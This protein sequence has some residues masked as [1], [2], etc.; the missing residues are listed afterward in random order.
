ME[1]P[2]FPAPDKTVQET[3]TILPG[4]QQDTEQQ[5]FN[6]TPAPLGRTPWRRGELTAPNTRV[7]HCQSR[8]ALLGLCQGRKG[9]SCTPTH[10]AAAQEL[11]GAAAAHGCQKSWS[12]SHPPQQEPGGWIHHFLTHGF[13]CSLRCLFASSSALH[14]NLLST[15]SALFLLAH[16]LPA[17]SSC[18][19]CRNTI[20]RIHPLLA[21]GHCASILREAPRKSHPEL[22]VEGRM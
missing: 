12:L 20:L 14:K 15:S 10:L 21:P 5:S 18:P 22:S 19:A 4:K 16:I 17:A 13:S 9:W 3:A 6:L 11:S 1:S 7:G 8:E 2:D